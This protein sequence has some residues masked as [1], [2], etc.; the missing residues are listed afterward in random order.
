M[1]GVLDVGAG[2]NPDSRASETADLYVADADHQF[3]IAEEWPLKTETYDGV[4]MSHVIEHVEDH[5][6]VM[7]EATRVVRPG[8]WIEVSVPLGA[9]WFADPTHERPWTWSTPAKFCCERSEAWQ[10]DLSLRLVD[11]HLDVRLFPPLQR[12]TPLLQ[13]LAE[14]WPAEAARRCSSGELTAYYRRIDG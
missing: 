7:E 5:A 4:V 2:D 9:D 1:T 10:P 6:H 14:F 8:G 12:L 3:D 13:E 11:R